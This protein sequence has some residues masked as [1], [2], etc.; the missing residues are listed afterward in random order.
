MKVGKDGWLELD[1]STDMT[2]AQQEAFER[3]KAAYAQAK[4]HRDV[5]E[6]LM[7]ASAPEGRTYVFGYNFGKASVKLVS[8]SEVKA[9]AASKPTQT[10]ADYLAQQEREGRGS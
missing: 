2:P 10:L 7:R 3:Y 4:A 5:Y 1:P 9:K 8:A 6:T